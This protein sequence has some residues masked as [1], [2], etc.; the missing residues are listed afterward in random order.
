MEEKIL[1]N[2]LL[3]TPI[4]HNITNYVTVNDCANIILACGGSPIM[5]DDY[6]EVEE[7]TCICNSLVINI[8]TLN[9]S[10]ILSMIKSGKKA[11][12]LG[13]PVILDPVGAGASAFRSNTVRK[14]LDEIRFS[15]IRGN[16]SEIKTVYEGSGSTKGVDAAQTDA[17]NESNLDEIIKLAQHLSE[18]T[19]AVIAIT[20][21]VDLVAVE[22]KAYVIRNGHKMMS[23][24]TGTGCMLTAVIGTFCGGNPD[25]LLES[26]KTAVCAMGISGELAYQKTKR[27]N[28][29]TSSFRTYLIDY[30]SKID[31]TL[32]KEGSKIESR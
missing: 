21:A 16:I 4:V 14:L 1:K 7:I 20:G 25:Q 31:T 11:N 18:K 10:T 19:G 13:I 9:E 5:A 27:T 17:I 22:N 30:M 6:N 26:T 2:V 8:G 24:I 12:E 3:R 15:V 23:Q 29:G 28:G 32:L